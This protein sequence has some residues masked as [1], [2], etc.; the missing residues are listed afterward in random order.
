M[1]E[2]WKDIEDYKGLYQVSNNPGNNKVENLEW[3]TAVENM[4]H[5]VKQGRIACGERQGLSKLKKQDVI[6]IRN[7]YSKFSRNSNT[8]TL[9]K[10]YKVGQ[11]VIWEIVNN[12]NWKHI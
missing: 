8:N 1:T 5:A 7:V 3:V 4:Q 12:R 11:A 6:N 10:Q 2:I 9:A